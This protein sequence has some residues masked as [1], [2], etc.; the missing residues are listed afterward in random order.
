MKT[1]KIAQCS[2]ANPMFLGNYNGIG[3]N[4]ARG[5]HSIKYGVFATSEGTIAVTWRI[6]REDQK[7][8]L[9]T[10]SETDNAP[11]DPTDDKKQRTGFGSVVLFRVAPSALDGTS[12]FTR[13]DGQR[14]WELKAPL[15][16]CLREDEE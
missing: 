4:T 5:H 11:S 8:L 1:I 2:F 10:W 14:I 15:D 13:E 3:Q 6:L 12:V 7:Y 16:R 9:L